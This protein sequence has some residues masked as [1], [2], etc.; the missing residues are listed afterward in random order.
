[1]FGTSIDGKETRLMVFL[2][3]AVI[4]SRI[5]SI[6]ISISIRISR[7]VHHDVVLGQLLVRHRRRRARHQVVARGRL[8]KSNDIAD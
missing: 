3:S 2:A 4:L 5:I 6:S 7:V 1:M 8:R